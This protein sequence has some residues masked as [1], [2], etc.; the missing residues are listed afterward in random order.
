[1]NKVTLSI[2][3]MMCNMCETHMNEA[4][5]KAVPEAKKVSSSHTSGETT[6]LFDGEPDMEAIQK[7]VD[8]T[9]YTLKGT[10]VSPYE[11]KGLFGFLK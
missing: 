1:M 9:G 3:G 5:R 8:E 2:D 4:I 7:A 6:F 10:D 11:K